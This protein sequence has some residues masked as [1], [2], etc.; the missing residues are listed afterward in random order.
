MLQETRRLKA[1]ADVI[2]T[3]LEGDAVLMHLTSGVYYGL[4]SVGASVWQKLE[5][6]VSREEIC[7]YI[8]ETFDVEPSVCRADI[9]VLL[10]E[11][12][13]AGLVETVPTR[14]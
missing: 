11:L 10:T 6:P 2:Y 4:D 5:E 12:E 14:H 8:A 1:S 9:Q 13:E 3:V 7:R